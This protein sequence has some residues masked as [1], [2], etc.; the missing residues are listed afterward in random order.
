MA[1]VPWHTSGPMLVLAETIVRKHIGSLLSEC[2]LLSDKTTWIK[3]YLQILAC[4]R[5]EEWLVLESDGAWI[6]NT[7]TDFS[8][9]EGESMVGG[10]DGKPLRLSGCMCASW[11]S[12]KLL[13]IGQKGRVESR[14]RCQKG[15]WHS[16]CWERGSRQCSHLHRGCEWSREI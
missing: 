13:M 3:I 12:M 10:S 14:G 7:F 1:I 15:F 5:K 6:K 4:L 11:G 9:V 8:E 2:L 16:S